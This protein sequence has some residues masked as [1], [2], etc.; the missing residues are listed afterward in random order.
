MISAT[1]EKHIADRINA[2]FD[3]FDNKPVFAADASARPPNDST[4]AMDEI[5]ELRAEVVALRKL[6]GD[7]LFAAE[8]ITKSAFATQDALIELLRGGQTNEVIAEKLAAGTAGRR[9]AE[10]ATLTERRDHAL[11]VQEAGHAVVAHALG[12]EVWSIEIDLATGD[13]ETHFSLV[14]DPVEP[15]V[16][17]S[18]RPFSSPAQRG[19]HAARWSAMGIVHGSELH[20]ADE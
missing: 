4:I 3:Q 18:R 14:E 10:H 5:T 15:C 19:L 2:A 1:Q 16:Q 12:A 11:A 9:V 20:D 6:I 8:L 17:Q 13:G 7:H